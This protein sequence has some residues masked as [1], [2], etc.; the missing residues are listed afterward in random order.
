VED[1]KTKSNKMQMEL[2]QVK[3]QY[4]SMEIKVS[5]END[6]EILQVNANHTVNIEYCVLYKESDYVGYTGNK[7]EE[8]HVFN[9]RLIWC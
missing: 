8:T 4:K 2:N 9:R 3:A 5:Q 7:L 1:W 6:N